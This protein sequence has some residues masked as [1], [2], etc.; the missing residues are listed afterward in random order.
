VPW[1]LNFIYLAVLVAIG[2]ETRYFLFSELHLRTGVSKFHKLGVTFNLIDYRVTRPSR[3]NNLLKR[4]DK[5]SIC[6][7]F[8]TLLNKFP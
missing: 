1:L 2:L 4:R 8:V 3:E 6:K 7:E 5:P